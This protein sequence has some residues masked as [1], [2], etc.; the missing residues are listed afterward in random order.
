QAANN[1][2]SPMAFKIVPLVTFGASSFS[3]TTNITID[4]SITVKDAR[5]ELYDDFGRRLQSTAIT[6]HTF[7]INRTGIPNGQYVWKVI[8]DKQTIGLGDVIITP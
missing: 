6:G 5:F 2:V 1:S 8:N 3:T 4:A 7:T